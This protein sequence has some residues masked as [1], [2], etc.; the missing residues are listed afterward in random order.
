MDSSSSIY[1]PRIEVLDETNTFSEYQQRHLATAVT[2]IAVDLNV[3]A[4][5]ITKT[6]LHIFENRTK[7]FS[8]AVVY[9]LSSREPKKFYLNIN[10]EV[11]LLLLGLPKEEFKYEYLLSLLSDED[12]FFNEIENYSLDE[13]KEFMEY[14]NFCYFSDVSQIKTAIGLLWGFVVQ[15]STE[16]IS[17][18]KILDKFMIKGLMFLPYLLL[19]QH[20]VKGKKMPNAN[21]S[22]LFLLAFFG[23]FIIPAFYRQLVFDKDKLLN[24]QYLADRFIS[25]NAQYKKC[26][27]DYLKEKQQYLRLLLT[28]IERVVRPR[29]ENGSLSLLDRPILSNTI[30]KINEDASSIERRIERLL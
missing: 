22:L 27:T 11:A 29:I 19:L 7:P 28:V 14:L 18:K 2:K 1:F 9:D 20:I 23:S 21:E 8:R 15:S 26:L 6:T 16:K 17:Y 5:I 10:K 24:E 4:E 13:I 30:S 25:Q 12:R 3:Q